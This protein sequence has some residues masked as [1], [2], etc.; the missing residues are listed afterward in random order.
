MNE[1]FELRT[2]HETKVFYDPKRGVYH[3]EKSEAPLLHCRFKDGK[4]ILS[5]SRVF[6]FVKNDDGTIS[7]VRDKKFLSARKDSDKFFW[8]PANK[9]WEHFVLVPIEAKP[10]EIK[11]VEAK[12]IEAKPSVPIEKPSIENIPPVDRDHCAGCTACASVCPRG[13]LT[14]VEDD[15]GFL[16][17]K[18]DQ[19]LCIKCG[20][21]EKVC[22]ILHPNKNPEPEI[23]YAAWIKDEA[24]REISSSGGL[25]FALMQSVIES[26]GVVCGAA[27]ENFVVKHI[28]V[29]REE[30]LIKLQ[31][32]KYVQSD[33]GDCFVEIKKLLSA[34]RKVLFAGT[35]CQVAG[36][37]NFIGDRNENLLTVDLICHGVP[38]PGVLRKYLEELRRR[39]P[40]AATVKFRDNVSGWSYSYAFT[41]FD[42]DGQKVFSRLNAYNPYLKAFSQNVITRRSCGRCE[43]CTAA[44]VGD[45][46][47]GDYWGITKIDPALN[48][49]KGTSLV[50]VNTDKGRALY[51][52]IGARLSINKALPVQNAVEHQGN[53]RRPSPESSLRE[54]FFTHF[55]NG[56][57]VDDWLANRLW[58]VGILN[59]CNTPNMGAAL[60]AYSLSR[61]I[62]SLGYSATIIN[63]FPPKNTSTYLQKLLHHYLKF[64]A[65]CRTLA[66]FR[67]INPQFKNIIVGSDQVWKFGHT[68]VNMLNW[69]AGRKTFISYAASFGD[70]EY[71]GKIP[72]ARAA[73][74]LTRFDFVSVR[75]ASGVDICKND[76]GLDAVHVVDPTMLLTRGH[77]EKMINPK[78]IVIPNKPFVAYMLFDEANKLIA[79]GKVLNDLREKFALWN[80]LKDKQGAFRSLSSWLS[81]IKNAEY[82]ITNSFHGTVF[83]ILFNKQFVVVAAPGRGEGRIPSLFK[84][85]RIPMTRYY[86]SIKDVSLKSFDEKID[87]NLVNALVEKE[88]EKGFMF[89]RLA[90]AAPLNQKDPVK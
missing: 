16:S 89:L 43:F 28:L 61:A 45:I 18:F 85:F 3:A 39:Y 41:L 2:F 70:D 66:D 37:K 46:T 6:D 58:S 50:F 71:S 33:P 19:S 57:G 15:E 87:Y 35:P 47:V 83:S 77:Y 24:R 64:S 44:R 38:S 55:K 90:L 60:V 29:D 62:E 11:V 81:A 78:R 69:A 84:M 74:L 8:M 34:G 53:L 40:T 1:V 10:I 86:Q 51:D 27:I 75:E 42:R 13:A 31:G 4:I 73:K 32:T 63:S 65:P 49:K 72:K 80:I 21:C 76:F 56:G 12:P 82:V 23:S 7:I 14:M 30:D 67:K 20:R 25:S 54:A 88:R 9:E 22:P 68:A 5:N 17:P 79:D 52:S 48:D 36:L 59:L 26:G